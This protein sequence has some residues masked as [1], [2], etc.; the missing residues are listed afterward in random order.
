[1]SG[2]RRVVRIVTRLNR[3]GPSRQLEALVPGLARLGWDGPV[4]TGEPEPTEEDVAPL[5][6][7][8]GVEV[9]RVPALARGIDARRD[10]AAWRWIRDRLRREGPDVVHTHM[11][12]AGALGRTAALS[13]GVPVRVH[14][15]HGHHLGTKPPAR[16]AAWAAE[17]A[18]GVATSGAVCLSPRQRDDLVAR[19]RVLP[20]SKAAVV[21][22]GLDLE[23]FVASAD[24][25][26]AVAIRR[27]HAPGGGVLALWLGRFVP[28]KDATVLVEAAVAAARHGGAP[29][30]VVLA[31][32]GPLEAEA[33]RRHGDLG[34]PS[35]VRFVGPVADAATWV[36]AADAV[37]L[38][39]RSE[40]TP[41]SLLEA[42][43][44][45]KPVVATAVG[46]V[47]DVVEPEGTGLLVPPCDPAA[48][49]VALARLA[50]DADLRARLGARAA[51][52]RERFS[53]ARLA[54]G[55]AS[56]YERLLSGG[57]AW[58]GPGARG[59]VGSAA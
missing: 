46:G 40:G 51:A 8:R 26:R 11:G 35:C 36:L 14:T 1:V 59:P 50:S 25:A 12:K 5:L 56:L 37:V 30:V 52:V 7:A 16:W 18:L 57:P 15:F 54:E 45:G 48:L 21:G 20:A 19:H 41:L 13:A 38:S 43:A 33:R 39:S 10:A 53:A 44:M 27:A 23:G 32:A 34:A 29:L 42:A 31:G 3:G 4:W 24:A 9:V 2:A 17:R 58:E 22:P 6:E 28:A 55:T 49:A 47:E